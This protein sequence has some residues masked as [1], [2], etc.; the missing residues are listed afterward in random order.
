MNAQGKVSHKC[1]YATKGR[2]MDIK[3]NLHIRLHK[4]FAKSLS[5]RCTK[6]HIQTG[7]SMWT[8]RPLREGRHAGILRC[9]VCDAVIPQRRT[10]RHQHTALRSAHLTMQTPNCTR[11]QFCLGTRSRSWLRHYVTNRKVAGSIRDEV[12]AFF[13]LPNSSSRTMGQ[14]SNK[15]LTEMSTRNLPGG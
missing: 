9:A 12:I 6:S 5:V 14:G 13:N 3:K 8:L 4:S 15:P 1:D 2:I 7:V 10:T 11:F